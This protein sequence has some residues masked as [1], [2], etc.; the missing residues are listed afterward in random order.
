[1]QLGTEIGDSMTDVVLV[2]REGPITRVKLN[3]PEKRNALSGEVWEA[4]YEVGQTI[5]GEKQTRVVVL[6]G[7]G[8]SFSSGLDLSSLGGGLL[9]SLAGAVGNDGKA[10]GGTV[11]PVKEI[12]RLQDAFSWLEQGSFVSIAA[13]QGYAL[14]AGWQLALACDFTIATDD[15]IFGLL[16][17]NYGLVPD[18]GGTVRLARSAGVSIAKQ[19]ILTGRRIS[20]NEAHTI[21]AVAQVVTADE[22]DETVAGAA[23]EVTR[24]SPTAIRLAKELVT[25]APTRKID[26]ALKAEAKAQIEAIGSAD[27]R[28]AMSAFMQR[29]D[30]AFS[31]TERD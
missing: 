20:A 2:E 30:P 1:M 21:G 19:L 22:L 23:S 10:E 7:E 27:F 4:L 5:L 18:M 12:M 16:E 8:Q 26:K 3:R 24:R 17:T 11:D 31:K 6:S 29:R 14:G 15:A 25:K 13:V 28:E 9:G